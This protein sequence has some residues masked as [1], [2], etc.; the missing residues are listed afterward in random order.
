MHLVQTVRVIAVGDG[1]EFD[2]EVGGGHGD[3]FFH[4][5]GCHCARRDARVP[6]AAATPTPF[7]SATT[8]HPPGDTR[9]AHA[10]PTQGTVQVS[11]PPSPFIAMI[12]SWYTLG[13]NAV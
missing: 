5:S 7:T 11:I 2:S 4:V 9:H 12:S 1:I 10:Q 8:L 13:L 3:G 6:C